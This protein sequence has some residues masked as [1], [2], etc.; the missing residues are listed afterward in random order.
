MVKIFGSVLSLLLWEELNHP[1]CLGSGEDGQDAGG[2]V[3]ERRF[4]CLAVPVSGFFHSSLKQL[5]L[6]AARDE[7]DGL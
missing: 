4:L 5:M 2:G 1:G 7:M 6:A 3:E